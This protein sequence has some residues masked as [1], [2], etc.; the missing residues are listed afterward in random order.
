VKKRLRQYGKY[1]NAIASIAFNC[2][3]T[4]LGIGVSYIW[5]DG[6]E[7]SKK[8]ERPAVFVRTLGDEV[9]VSA[10]F[11]RCYLTGLLTTL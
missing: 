5:D 3:G 11:I 4:K 10:W 7:G 2:D 8:A 9:K 1:N 6:E